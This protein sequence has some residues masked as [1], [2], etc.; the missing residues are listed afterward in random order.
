VASG[1]QDTSSKR[2]QALDY[3]E[4]IGQVLPMSC[5]FGLASGCENSI[6]LQ[7]KLARKI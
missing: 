2:F 5:S 7:Y 3:Q 1:K 4:I 6:G